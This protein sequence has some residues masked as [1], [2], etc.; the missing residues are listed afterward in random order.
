M[1]SA[2]KR[3][4]ILASRYDSSNSD[5]QAS[6]HYRAPSTLENN[7][8][9]AAALSSSDKP[10]QSNAP[11]LNDSHSKPN[12]QRRPP[13]RGPRF[14]RPV[15]G[16]DTLAE[17][18]SASCIS[19]RTSDR[20]LMPKGAESHGAETTTSSTHF[21]AVSG[22][23]VLLDIAATASSERQANTAL[24]GP[25]TLWLGATAGGI[26]CSCSSSLSFTGARDTMGA[27]KCEGGCCACK[28]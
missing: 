27:A 23:P 3:K 7:A 22:A 26:A 21:S 18:D 4:E 20:M 19:R 12:C 10:V 17:V 24:H 8:S 11:L 1:P 9:S 2:H 5:A 6:T 14:R 15:C 28:S 25:R 16:A 13:E